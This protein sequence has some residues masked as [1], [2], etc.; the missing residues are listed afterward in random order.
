MHSPIIYALLPAAGA[1]P[2][3][4]VRSLQSLR[5]SSSPIV[6]IHRPDEE[7]PIGPDVKPVLCTGTTVGAFLEVG[8]RHAIADLYL[9]IPPGVR[10]HD[11]TAPEKI[12][13]AFNENP[14][15]GLFVADYM[16]E[17]ILT[18]IYPLGDDLTERE[19]FGVAWGFP[20]WALEKIGGA[21]IS[22]RYA[23]F[24]DLRLKLA[25]IGPIVH[26][27]QPLFQV[28]QTEETSSAEKLFYP[29]RGRFGGF[30]YLFL[31]PEEEKEIEEVFY[32]CLHRR[33]AWID[34]KP[35]KVQP[36]PLNPGQPLVT[37]IIPVHNRARFLP[38]A[39]DSIL[40]GSFQNF[41]IIIVD[42]A[43]TDSTRE[44]ATRFCRQDQRIRL[45]ENK[46]NLI[47]KA[48]NLGV[49]EA[50]GRY[51]AQLDSDDEYTPATLETMVSHLESHP[52]CALA[53]SYYELMDDKGVTLEEFGVIKHLE[54]NE[55]NI[56]RVDGAGAVRV[57]HKCVIE[58]FGGFN[59]V[60]FPNYGEDYDLVLKVS[61]RYSVDRVHQ[62][63]YRYRRHPGNTDALRRPQDKI[64]AKTFAR[65]RAI[66]RRQKM[67]GR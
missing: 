43:S 55:N 15:A 27:Q 50:R 26:L 10:L 3:M 36:V 17:D 65:S 63:A 42:N 57:W 47:A 62:V 60:D 35:E 20:A 25:E 30:S 51:I 1:Q 64:R 13:R 28:R 37:V 2:D 7:S 4:I 14:E 38:K 9:W 16:V 67:N 54:Y 32:R 18:E 66:E 22:L 8:R 34:L 33:G 24:Y 19:D 31:G 5:R 29:G 44:V 6:Y 59:E 23:A 41:E 56:L 12:A 61:E 40:N 52:T 11:R 46:V 49:R 48:L 21:D 53:I 39:I 58:E 45:L